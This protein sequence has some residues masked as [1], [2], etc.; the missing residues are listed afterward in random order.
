MIHYHGTPISGSLVSSTR[1]LASRFAMVSFARPDQLSLVLEV[2]KGFALDS[3]AFSFWKRGEPIDWDLYR[4][5][6]FE[7]YQHPGYQFSLIPDV[8]G[9]SDEENDELLKQ[10]PLP[11]G[12]PVFHQ[13]ESLARLKRL[14]EYYPTVALASTETHI[15]SYSFD[16]WM[17]DCMRVIC[18]EKGKPRCKIHGLRML[19]PKIFTGYP[20][21]SADSTNV[22]QNCNNL[23]Q[24][25]G[26]YKPV[27]TEVRG[28]VIID[29]IETY[30]SPAFWE[31]PKI[32]QY[33]LFEAVG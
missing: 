22:A 7:H 14:V 32:E 15:P 18:D 13:N 26:P 11:G 21:A 16:S 33:Q 19:N 24:W 4:S 29:R 31:E 5:F 23:T 10:Y 3:G 6:V 1:L 30:Q 9:G 20:L 17:I 27:N 8:I 25:S 12:V 2:C 28:A